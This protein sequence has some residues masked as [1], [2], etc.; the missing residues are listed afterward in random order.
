MIGVNVMPT[1]E[2]VLGSLAEAYVTIKGNRYK[3]F[4]LISFEG[5]VSISSKTRGILGRTGKV[6]YPTG[7]SGSWKA[8][9][10]YNTPIFRKLIYE[11]KKTG[12]FPAFEISVSN[13]NSTGT[14]GRQ[15]VV[16]KGCYIESAI[17]SKIDIEA[18]GE[19]NEDISGT[20]NDFELPEQFGVMAG[21]LQTEENTEA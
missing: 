14:I 19:L 11:F 17:L 15:T 12:V 8:T 1:D 9:I 5:S 16:Y 7:W 3:L 4:N 2:Q 18:D 6:S 10:S 20:F 21:M 13:E